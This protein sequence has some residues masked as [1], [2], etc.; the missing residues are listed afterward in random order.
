MTK[1]RK[2]GLAIYAVI[3]IIALIFIIFIAPDSLFTKKP[4]LDALPVSDPIEFVDYEEQK[5]N[6]KQNKYTYE[7]NILDSMSD[8]TYNY[9]CTGTINIDEEAGTCTQPEY[10]TY[11]VSTKEEV[12]KNINKNFIDPAYIFNLVKDIEPELIKYQTYR[13]YTYNLEISGLDTK[14]LIRTDVQNITEITIMNTY[15]QYHLKYSDI[16]V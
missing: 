11:D 16:K 9:K 7:Y 12:Y 8:T 6:L 13:D 4:D 10:I 5:E 14:I 1:K 2:I 15:S 3:I